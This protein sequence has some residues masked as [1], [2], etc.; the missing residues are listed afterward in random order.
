MSVGRI[1]THDISDRGSDMLYLS[2]DVCHIAT[3][4]GSGNIGKRST[5]GKKGAGK[6]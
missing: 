6:M 4:G 5:F 2:A 1:I 3:F